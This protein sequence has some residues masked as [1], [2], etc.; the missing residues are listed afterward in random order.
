MKSIVALLVVAGCATTFTD[1]FLEVTAVRSVP[2]LAGKPANAMHGTSCKSV[3]TT[4][5]DYDG[6]DYC[7]VAT[8][9]V[10]PRFA[11]RIHSQRS[12]PQGVDTDWLVDIPASIDL[13]TLPE[14]GAVPNAMCEAA[15][16]QKHFDSESHTDVITECAV[17]PHHP[18]KTEP[19]LVCAF[20]HER[21]A[22]TM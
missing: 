6:I 22:E 13:K 7:A 9:D 8:F 21:K 10:K 15:G 11:C 18:D 20:H 2:T 3:C 16:C 4:K 5:H 12:S 1:H 19:F 14:K 17:Y